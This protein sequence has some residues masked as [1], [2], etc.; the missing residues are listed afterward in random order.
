MGRYEEV[1]ARSIE[2]PEGFWGEAAAE[3]TWYK[4]WDRVLDDTNP[5]FY[6]WFELN[7]CYNALDRHV[8]GGRADQVALIYDSPVSGRKDK[9]T[10]RELRDKVALFAGVL[11]G[12]DVSKG[13][14]LVIYMPMISQA[15]IAMLACARLGVVHSVV[16]GGFAPNELAVR[17][18]DAKPKIIVTASGAIEVSR[19]IEY[20]PMVDKAIQLASHKPE[21]VILY[22]RPEIKADMI[23]GRDLDW[24]ELMG[25]A[26]R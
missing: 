1:F 9:L 13:D 20:K 17:I 23:E 8:E 19:I 11:K 4:Q 3:I 2:D 14:T 12:L 24:D 5:P 7:T 26:Y 15:V 22:Q 18:D 21:K 16:F 25:T 10:Y 6:R